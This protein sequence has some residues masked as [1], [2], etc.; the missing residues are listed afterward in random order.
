MDDP[1]FQ[2]PF[3]L[4]RLLAGRLDWAKL[5]LVLLPFACLLGYWIDA[6]LPAPAFLL[7][8]RRYLAFQRGAELPAEAGLGDTL[9]VLPD[10]LVPLP[11]SPAGREALRKALPDQAVLD[12]V[13][14]DLESGLGALRRARL[15]LQEPPLASELAALQRA[16][17]EAPLDLEVQDRRERSLLQAVGVRCSPLEQRVSFDLLLAPFARTSAWVEVRAGDSVLYRSTGAE[18]PRDLVLRL[19]VERRATRALSARLKDAAGRETVQWFSLGSELEEKPKVLV[20]SAKKPARSFVEALYPARRAT[21]EE[22][23][24]LDLL[25]YELVVV[26]GVAIGSLRG[27]LR[28]GLLDIAAR[29]TGSIL[30]VADS[31]DFGRKGDNPELEE[32]LPVTLLPRSLKDLPDLAVL[33]LIDVSG[34]MFGDK[35]SLAKLTGLEL[36][37]NL[38]PSDRVGMLLFS[39]EHRWVYTFQTNASI[40]ASPVLEP[41]TAGGGTDLYPALMDGLRPLADQP[42]QA[43]H[44][45]LITDGV[46]KPADFQA[47]ADRARSQGISI[48]A[49]GVGTDANRPLLER[50]ALRTNGRYYAVNSVEAIPGLLFEDRMSEARAIFGQGKTPVLAMNGRKVATVTGHG[51]VHAGAHGLRALRQRCGGPAPGQQGSRQS[52]GAVLRERSLRHLHPGLLRCS[53]RGRRLQ[54]PAGHALRTRPCPGAGW[55]RPRE[56]SVCSPAATRWWNRCSC[57]RRRDSRPWRHPSGAPGRKAGP[58]SWCPPGM[59]CGMPRS[60][61]A[62]AAWPPSRSP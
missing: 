12:P 58:P 34:S 42:I 30:F 44:V 49:M 14:R 11:S 55:W 23:A 8:E 15:L 41:L 38:K 26:D 43:K 60:W 18:L 7:P 1:N 20:I 56:G 21:P 61:T 22:A 57:S 32:L 2:A 50:L 59:A 46:T 9:V 19:S 33:I 52:G 54:G 39:D 29:R 25:A 16:A 53:R 13:L 24:G 37:R 10:R 47:F 27:R 5:S 51:A 62:G 17:G 45:V 36:L 3:P 40:T 6:P 28:A 35:L 31:P 4:A 48:S